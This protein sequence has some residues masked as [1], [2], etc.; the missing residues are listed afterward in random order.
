MGT[1]TSG[2]MMAHS[3]AASVAFMTT[4]LLIGIKTPLGEF[5]T[6]FCPDINLRRCLCHKT[7]ICCDEFVTPR[8]VFYVFSFFIHYEKTEC[9]TMNKTKVFT[10]LTCRDKKLT[11]GYFY[12]FS[13]C[14]EVNDLFVADWCD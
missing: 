11:F 6:F 13:G 10:G 3:A 8:E 7:G 4:C 5:C 9:A 2:L 14:Q 1:A 12:L